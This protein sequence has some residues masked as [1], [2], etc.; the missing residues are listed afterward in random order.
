MAISK[1]GKHGHAKVHL[2][3]LDLFTGKKYEDIC[4]S[5]HMMNVP[6]IARKQYQ[7]HDFTTKQPLCIS[8]AW[9]VLT[10][11]LYITRFYTAS[12]DDVGLNYIVYCLTQ[13]KVV[14]RQPR[15]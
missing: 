13:A 11:G 4:P 9:Y 3:G 7:V 14:L 1:P 6:N 2:V 8:H 12:S 15:H 10:Q 5:S